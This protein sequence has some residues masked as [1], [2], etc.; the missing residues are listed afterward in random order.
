MEI[1]LN[2]ELL[3]NTLQ[4]INSVIDKSS[5]KPILSNFVIRT[6]DGENKKVEF[7][8]TDY[9]LSL[10]ETIS[11]EINEKGSICVNAKKIGQTAINLPFISVPLPSSAENH[12][13]KNAIYYK[14][15]N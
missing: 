5:A 6:I 4:N 13:L 8:S 15:K 14:K 3:S 9:E 2:R 1:T 12:Q 10:I 11:A 7:S